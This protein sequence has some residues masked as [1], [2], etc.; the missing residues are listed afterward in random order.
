MDA[1]LLGAQLQPSKFQRCTRIFGLPARPHG[2]RAQSCRLQRRQQLQPSLVGAGGKSVSP[3]V[4]SSSSSGAACSGQQQHG[5]PLS[6]APMWAKLLGAAAAFAAWYSVAS[7]MR[8]ASPFLSLTLAV[9]SSSEGEL[10][11]EVSNVWIVR[12]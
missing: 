2:L 9:G 10:A 12:S 7:A 5:D 1:S 3:V 8:A 11:E 4:C 6:N